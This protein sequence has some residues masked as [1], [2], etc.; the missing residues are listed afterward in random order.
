MRK[1]KWKQN[2][3][4][5]ANLHTGTAARRH[6]PRRRMA[7]VARAQ[8]MEIGQFAIHTTR[9]A[10]DGRGF[11][12]VSELL[13]AILEFSSN[14]SW[15]HGSY[16]LILTISATPQ[17]LSG[18]RYSSRNSVLTKRAFIR[19]NTAT[20]KHNRAQLIHYWSATLFKRCRNTSISVFVCLR[21]A[22]FPSSYTADSEPSPAC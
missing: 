6:W 4:A 3:Q 11:G 16:L 7:N 12:C 18:G 5:P 22:N 19:F 20:K 9:W 8:K 1:W 21:S 14:S 2:S 17:S 10:V 15:S 13:I